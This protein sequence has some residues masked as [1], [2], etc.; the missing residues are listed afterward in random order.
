MSSE[1]KEAETTVEK[2]EGGT[3]TDEKVEATVESDD[4]SGSATVKGDTSK[5]ATEKSAVRQAQ[6]AHDSADKKE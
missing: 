1:K 5:S 4:S 2:T 6:A 3:F